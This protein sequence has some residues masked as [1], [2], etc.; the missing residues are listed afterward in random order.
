[1]AAAW[2][3]PFAFVV[4][5]SAVVSAVVTV[6][7]SRLEGESWDVI[8]D[9][10]LVAGAVIA[11]LTAAALGLVALAA[12]WWEDYMGNGDPE[13]PPEMEEA[14]DREHRERMESDPEYR[15]EALAAER[16]DERA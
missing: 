2:W 9:G 8:T 6:V 1:M 15:R 4:S 14:L 10:L 7:V 5:G 13:M 16:E 11:V 12:R 3:K